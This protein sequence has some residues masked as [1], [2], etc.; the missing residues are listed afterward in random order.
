MGI[1]RWC[2]CMCGPRRISPAADTRHGSEQSLR[3]RSRTESI[4]SRITLVASRDGHPLLHLRWHHG[5][6]IEE[7]D[8]S[9]RG[10][11]YLSVSGNRLPNL[12]E[13]KLEVTTSD[14]Q[15]A[16][17]T[18]QVADVTRALCAVSRICDKGNTVTFQAEGGSLRTQMA[19][20]LTSDGRTT[21]T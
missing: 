12:G 16:T 7:S 14:G 10:Q 2:V 11:T 6:R 18:Y 4:L 20:A 3:R 13:K 19:F 5:W 1:E 9:R 8:G 17:A 15:A 21:C